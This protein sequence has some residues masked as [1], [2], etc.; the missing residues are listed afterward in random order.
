MF[1]QVVF[2]CLSLLLTFLFFLYGFNHYYLIN[3][4]R[5]YRTP[6]LKDNPGLRPAVAIHLPVYNERYVIRRL[7]E[8][9]ARMAMEYG[10]DRVKILIIDYSDDD[11]TVETDQVIQEYQDQQFHIEVLRRNDRRGFK[12]GALQ[13]ALEQTEEDFIAIFDADFLPSADFLL[14]TMPY[15]SQ[16]AKLGIIQSRWT[17][18]NRGYNFLTKA[19]AIGIDVH[20]LIDQPG[21]F[22]AGC[23][24]N[25]NGSGGILRKK[26]LVEAG[27]WQSDT[28]SEDLDASYRIQSQGYRFLYLKDL[29]CPGEIPPTVPSFK[30]QQGRWAC[31]SLRTARKLL[32]TL[33]ADR[34]LGTK[35]RLQAIIHLTG[36]MVHPLMFISFVLACLATL[37]N[38]DIFRIPQASSLFLYNYHLGTLR[39]NSIFVLQNLAWVLLGLMILFCTVAVWISPIVSLRIQHFSVSHNI[40]SLLVLFLI[41]CGISLSNTIEA[42][43]A[44]LTNRNWAFR[45][46]PKYAILQANEEWRG[47]RYQVPLDYIF[48]WSWLVWD[49]ARFR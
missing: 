28:L 41:G 21:R 29:P 9:C 44:L 4:A 46:T 25:F 27:G 24:Q 40:S 48:S 47:K 19:I 15:F 2:L 3:S 36:Y 17:H 32:P 39:A 13:A 1:V 38:V 22:A 45:R 33:L 5:K 8:A 30:K 14:R 20:F 42:G 37:L 11:S 31:G 43:K 10:I 6:D 49:L 34:T 12:A 18:L 35:K 23:L 26:A 7:I 16:D